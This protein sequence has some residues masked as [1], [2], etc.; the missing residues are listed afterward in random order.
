[1]QFV[2]RSSAHAAS[3]EV[4]PNWLQQVFQQAGKE[5]VGFAGA[6]EVVMGAGGGMDMLLELLDV[7]GG[8]GGV[9]IE[10]E[11][12]GQGAEL[13]VSGGGGGGGGT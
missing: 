1:M 7:T 12:S 5:G 2:A 6:E 11:D 13:V 8:G 4:M 3:F 10:L 9:E